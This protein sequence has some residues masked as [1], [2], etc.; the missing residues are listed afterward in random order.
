MSTNL[1]HHPVINEKTTSILSDFNTRKHCLNRLPVIQ[2]AEYLKA[3][4]LSILKI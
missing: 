2:E 3:L 4:N 1:T